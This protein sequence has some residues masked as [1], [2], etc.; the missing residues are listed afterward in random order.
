MQS[1][2]DEDQGL[3]E[4]C[5]HSH[6]T[7]IPRFRIWL[8]L[9]YFHEACKV[10]PRNRNTVQ[11]SHVLKSATLSSMV[12]GWI[13]DWN[14]WLQSNVAPSSGGHTSTSAKQR[15]THPKPSMFND[16]NTNFL[17]EMKW[18][19]KNI[20]KNLHIKTDS[21]LQLAFLPFNCH[22]TLHTGLW[23]HRQR[24]RS[25]SRGS[26]EISFRSVAFI[27][28]HPIT[29]NPLHT[30]CLKTCL[31]ACLAFLAIPNCYHPAQ[32]KPNTILWHQQKWKTKTQCIVHHTMFMKG[33][34]EESPPL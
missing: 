26:L 29:Q 5:F 23:D 21:E 6:N 7:V 3:P 20:R 24:K 28:Y 11:T 13:A 14:E 15:L 4:R 1:P 34:T 18:Q 8:G 30:L 16:T 27:F 25:Q 32:C 22:K 33:W 9:V 12:L 31:L 17:L 10:T 2:Q 19:L